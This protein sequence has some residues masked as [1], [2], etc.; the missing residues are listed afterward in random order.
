VKTALNLQVPL[1][2]KILTKRVTV[3]FTYLVISFLLNKNCG[4]NKH[5]FMLFGVNA[6]LLRYGMLLKTEIQASDFMHTTY[7]LYF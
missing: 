5:C 2:I 1:K 7:G 4:E 3:N 6:L